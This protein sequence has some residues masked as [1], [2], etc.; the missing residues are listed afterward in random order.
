MLFGERARVPDGYAHIA[1]KLLVPLVPV[2]CYRL[3]DGNARLDIELMFVPDDAADRDQIYRVALDFGVRTLEC[4]ITAHPD[5]WVV[6]TPL[7]ISSF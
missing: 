5:Q 3:P 4:A 1:A 2:F 7:W 6:T